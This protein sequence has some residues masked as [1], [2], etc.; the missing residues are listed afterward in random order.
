MHVRLWMFMG[1]CIWQWHVWRSC[2][3]PTG[4]FVISIFRLVTPFMCIGNNLELYLF[5]LTPRCLFLH[6]SLWYV[7]LMRAL[8]ERLNWNIIQ[9]FDQ[10][11]KVNINLLLWGIW[12]THRF[13][14]A[15]IIGNSQR[16]GSCYLHSLITSF[17]G[18]RY[19]DCFGEIGEIWKSCNTFELT[20]SH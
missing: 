14:S 1:S 5:R 10:R 17:C 15:F 16:F 8:V 11:A 9:I 3:H 20:W 12:N 19:Q 18:T 2:M 4:A 13:K 6:L 7:R